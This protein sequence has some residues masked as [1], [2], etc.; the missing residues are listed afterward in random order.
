MGTSGK[1]AL[2]AFVVVIIAAIA[3][4]LASPLFIDDKVEEKFPGVSEK[5]RAEVAPPIPDHDQINAM[6]PEELEKARDEILAAAAREPAHEMREAMPDEAA[7]PALVAQGKFKDADIIHKGSGDARL[8][9]LADGSHLIRLENF[10]VTN[11]PALHVYLA[12]HAAPE[13]ASEVTGGGYFDLGK[14]KGNIGN[15]NY[16]VPEDIAVADYKSVVIWCR[17]FSVLFSAAS[18]Q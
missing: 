17:L 4:F 9:R 18:L 1:K 6:S 5:P 11:G 8:Y 3:W 13:T 7:E 2:I 16:E 15:Q 10:E 14:L 12:K